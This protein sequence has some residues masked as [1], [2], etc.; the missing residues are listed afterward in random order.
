[1]VSGGVEDV[2][3]EGGSHTERPLDHRAV[4]AL[5]VFDRVTCR[6]AKAH[7]KAQGKIKS[8]Q[9]PCTALDLRHQGL[10]GS[11]TGAKIIR[12]RTSPISLP[13]PNRV[14]LWAFA[15]RSG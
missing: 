15:R 3:G 8:N 12:A 5:D 11:L 1:M 4:R 14:G 6:F 7:W 13:D 10:L 9:Q 2:V